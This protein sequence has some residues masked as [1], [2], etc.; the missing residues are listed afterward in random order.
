MSDPLGLLLLTYGSPE[1]LEDVEEYLTNVRGGRAP[2]DELVEEFKD[3]YRTIGGS[4]LTRMTQNQAEGAARHLHE[5]L[6][7]T[8]VEPYVGMRFFAPYI[9][10]TVKQMVEDGIRRAVALILSPQYSPVLMGGYGD[11]LREGLEGAPGELEV[12]LVESWWDEPLYH[13][14]VAARVREALE[15][16]PREVRSDVPLLLTAHSI[17]R[18][19]ADENPDYVRQLKQTAQAIASIVDHDNWDFAYQSAGHTREEWL[20][21]DMTD[22]FPGLVEDGHEHVIIAPFQ[23]LSDHL[24]ILY[25]I[26]V[27]ARRQAE[28]V[29]LT[30]H[31]IA[32]LNRHETFLRALAS[33]AARALCSDA[34][35][36]EGLK[37]VEGS[38]QTPA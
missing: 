5:A 11:A 2:G 8:P 28:E 21:P 7:D 18:S 17:P 31:R 24:E 26:D 19:V 32:S 1:R 4:P 36:A 9:E 10:E 16:V 23:F 33:V 27:A 37:I 25:D 12:R 15:D 14:A 20:K 6:E 13:R 30:F 22:L 34:E 35:P 38:S 29:G 3:R